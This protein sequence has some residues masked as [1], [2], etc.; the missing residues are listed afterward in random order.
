MCCFKI[1][2]CDIDFKSG[3]CDHDT[4]RVIMEQI[5]Q[6]KYCST[7][8]GINHRE[9]KINQ[10]RKKTKGNIETARATREVVDLLSL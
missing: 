4:I 5:I 9:L 8:S 6:Q 7:Q 10:V 3:L 1:N 2:L